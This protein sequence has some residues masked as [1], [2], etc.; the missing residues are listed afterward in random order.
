MR[1][2]LPEISWQADGDS[3]TLVFP[4]GWPERHPLT[5]ADLELEQKRLRK[6]D[7]DLEYR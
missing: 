3:L 1:E 4:D 7:F 5:T 6:I 2:Q